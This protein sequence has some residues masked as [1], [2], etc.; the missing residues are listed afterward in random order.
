MPKG[1]A[2][3]RPC[4]LGGCGR[5]ERR[6]DGTLTQESDGHGRSE[7]RDPSSGDGAG[8]PCGGPSG[9]RSPARLHS[10]QRTTAHADQRIIGL[11]GPLPLAHEGCIRCVEDKRYCLP[12]SPFVPAV[13][14]DWERCRMRT[15]F[16]PRCHLPP[17]V[18]QD[19]PPNN[20]VRRRGSQ[21]RPHLSRPSDL[22]T[23]NRNAEIMVQS[24]AVS[25]SSKLLSLTTCR[26]MRSG[27][28]QALLPI[29]ASSPRAIKPAAS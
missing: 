18:S 17:F 14:R 24:H 5:E 12:V 10:R 16:L 19:C 22:S 8:P 1:V 29:W 27:Y 26:C 28:P 9:P 23:T 21:P 11:P 4:A 3:S 2:P 15:A 20:G 13:Q 7:T 25:S 6:P